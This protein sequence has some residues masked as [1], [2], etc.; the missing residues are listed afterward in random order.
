MANLLDKVKKIPCCSWAKK[1]SHSGV[2]E[3]SS[4]YKTDY[5]CLIFVSKSARGGMP[6]GHG[7]KF[8][9][10]VCML[11]GPRGSLSQDLV[12]L[13][14]DEFGPALSL[15]RRIFPPGLMRYLNVKQQ[16]P[17]N[18]PLPTPKQPQQVLK[19]SFHHHYHHVDVFQTH[20]IIHMCI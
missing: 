9:K 14:V 17:I 5:S 15:M 6:A 19:L 2:A 3:M 8:F 10:K 11:Q 12:A 7:L 1:D 4:S 16:A 20:N 18:P 13:W